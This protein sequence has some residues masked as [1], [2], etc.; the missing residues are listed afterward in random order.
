MA[1]QNPIV[2]K[3]RTGSTRT[4][5]PAAASLTARQVLAIFRRH[6]LLIIIMTI[7]GFAASVG[8]WKILQIYFPRYVA[9]TYIE[10]LSPAPSDPLTIGSVQL[11]NNLQYNY[12]RSI[13]N[14]IKQQ[15]SL[16]ELL[17]RNK[18][19]QT[20]W[21]SGTGGN[22]QKAVRSLDRN[23]GAYPQRDSEFVEI[24]MTCKK[25]PEAALIVNEMLDLFLTKQGATKTA[26]VTDKLIQLEKQKTAVETE[27]QAVEKNLDKIRK[28]SNIT[29]LDAPESRY[30]QDTTTIKL[31]N[32]ELEKDKL[33]LAIIQFQTDMNNLAA[34]AIGPITEQIE[35]IAEKDPV[36]VSLTQQLAMQEAKLA[37]L[38]ER[39]GQD[40]ISVQEMNKLVDETKRAKEER[41]AEIGEQIRRANLQNARD[42]LKALQ[43]RFQ[44]L[45]TL[46]SQTEAEKKTLDNARVE[47]DRVL[48]IRDERL[49]MLD[50]IK[51]QIEKWKIIAT[52]PETPKVRSVGLAPEPLEMVTSRQWWLWLPAC[53]MLGLLLGVALSFLAEFSN[54][55]VRTSSDV[56]KYLDIPLL[57]V[58][59]DA[60]EDNQAR[61]V[62]PGE[63]VRNAPYS[64]VSESYR[65]CRTNLKLLAKD[66]PVKY[67]LVC[68]G[69]SGDGATSTAVNLA[70]TFVADDKKVLLIDA[71]FRRPGLNRI[72]PRMQGIN[73]K[74]EAFGLGLSSVLTGQCP[75]SD[76]VRSSGIEG[77]DIIDCGPVPSNPTELLGNKIMK[78]ILAK[79]RRKYNYVII[80]GPAVLMVSDSKVIAGLIDAVLLVFNAATTSRGAAQRTIQELGDFNA[81]ILGC[82][83]YAARVIKGGYF[84]QRFNYFR[85]YQKTLKSAGRL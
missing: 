41:K 84:E 10:V 35:I 1:E 7:I 30:F 19:K 23:F 37:G 42:G 11:E 74:A 67:L 77:L 63:I 71:N 6:I 16:Q 65:Q 48:K 45:E 58:I 2:E 64:L 24:S 61:R 73:K 26:E 62:N 22:I 31:N 83:L 68:G 47:Y 28:D 14:L 13:S 8:I 78:Q 15:R 29:D 70:M 69:M 55:L 40:H 49:V 3:Y 59:P 85:S 33:N 4:A 21:F 60:S 44:E 79:Q 39:F 56:T 81:R 76:A 72:F 17:E 75:F 43:E 36:L 52:D 50:S 53:T 82:V 66:N 25:A 80:D 38:L 57:G 20:E 27:L 5:M 46:R 54:E 18:I 12:R 34:L 32:L 51:Q 9:R